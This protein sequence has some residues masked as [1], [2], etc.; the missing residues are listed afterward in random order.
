MKKGNENKKE[1]GL[2]MSLIEERMQ[3]L[4]KLENDKKYNRFIVDVFDLLKRYPYPPLSSNPKRPEQMKSYP[5]SFSG[6]DTSEMSLLAEELVEK[7]KSQCDNIPDA[8]DGR[9]RN[10]LGSTCR[11]NIRNQE[12]LT[13]LS[14]TIEVRPISDEH[15]YLRLTDSF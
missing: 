11:R 8:K 15:S 6:F 10:W 1:I 12:G 13:C 9:N 4:A 2:I 5:H 3:S 14:L 7:L